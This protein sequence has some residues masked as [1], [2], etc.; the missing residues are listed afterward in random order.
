MQ[1]ISPMRPNKSLGGYLDFDGR[2]DLLKDYLPLINLLKKEVTN[3]TISHRF[4][5]ADI[6]SSFCFGADEAK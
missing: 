4:S 1:M 3:E 5:T 6:N 2:G